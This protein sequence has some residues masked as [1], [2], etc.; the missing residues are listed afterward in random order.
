MHPSETRPAPVSI[1]GGDDRAARRSLWLP[2]AVLGTLLLLANLVMANHVYQQKRADYWTIVWSVAES[3]STQVANWL[4]ERLRSAGLHATSFPQ[5]E[6]YTRW[7]VEGDLHARDLLL[8]RLKQFADSGRFYAVNLLD[9][10]G[11][12]LAGDAH[13]TLQLPAESLDAAMMSAHRRGAGFIGPFKD[14]HGSIHLD[15]L[16]SLPVEGSES[17]PLVLLH[18]G[19]SDYFPE[20]LRSF[21]LPSTSGEVLLFR[22]EG[23]AVVALHDLRHVEGSAFTRLVMSEAPDQLAVKIAGAGPAD[24]ARVEGV[25]YR[26]EAVFGSG[27]A[28]PGTDWFLVAKMDI[29]EVAG[30]ALR[31]MLPIALLSLL[32]FSAVG[33]TLVNRRQ[34]QHL[35]QAR[36]IQKVQGERLQSLQLLKAVADS[37]EDAIFVKDPD[38]RYLL[39]NRAACQMTGR[40][41]DEV[42][43]RDDYSVFPPEQAEMLAATH[44]RV[45]AE[46][47]AVMA[48]EILHT[49]HGQRA[50]LARKGPLHDDSGRLIGVYGIS[51][52]VTDLEHSSILLEEHGR[53]L[54]ER[55][56]ELER[57]NEAMVGRELDMLRLKQ[58][59]NELSVRLGLKPPFGR[60]VIE[61]PEE[62]S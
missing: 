19:A 48:R 13:P 31:G 34:R 40:S 42:L 6:L 16:A 4:E 26:G 25:D 58:Q 24:R 60:R 32:C 56:Q 11:R 28:I 8:L 46:N 35:R 57:F 59:V 17:T 44:R 36:T 53:Q 54:E 1:A 22:V 41:E 5:A 7:Q 50:V 18:T 30:A 23:D 47:R 21:P 9:G 45:L 43:G 20:S 37:A 52:D 29:S 14:E 2:L 3:H 51:R 33:A 39:F 49:A 38:G 62:E 15:F 27:R 55:N 10:A 12:P 61:L